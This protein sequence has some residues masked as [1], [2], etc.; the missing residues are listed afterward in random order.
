VHPLGE[1]GLISK[2][3]KGSVSVFARIDHFRIGDK[4]SRPSQMLRLN[5]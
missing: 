4:P 1:I 2:K 3:Q 5:A